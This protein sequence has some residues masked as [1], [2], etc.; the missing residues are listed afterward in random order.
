VKVSGASA[1]AGFGSGN[2]HNGYSLQLGKCKSFHGRAV[3]AVRAGTQAGSIIVEVEADRLPPR[4]TRIDAVS[5]A[6]KQLQ[7]E[8]RII[9]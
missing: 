5:G 8:Q 3:V 2:P 9:M 6:A 7:L 4:K 1:L